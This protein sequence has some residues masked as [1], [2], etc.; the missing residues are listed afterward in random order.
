MTWRIASA[1][2]MISSGVALSCNL[3]SIS[4]S[5]SL[6]RFFP[7][8]VSRFRPGILFSTATT[9]SR[10]VRASFTLIAEASEGSRSIFSTSGVKSSAPW[11][12]PSSASAASR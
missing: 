3:R 4:S 1:K 7:A 2:A 9:Q 10:M 5:T 8:E 11:A 6:R 12:K